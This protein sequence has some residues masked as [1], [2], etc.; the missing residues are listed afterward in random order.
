MFRAG[1]KPSSGALCSLLPAEAVFWNILLVLLWRDSIVSRTG[2]LHRQKALLND[3][4]VPL[5]LQHCLLLGQWEAI[6]YRE[7]LTPVFLESPALMLG[8]H[9]HQDP[10]QLTLLWPLLHHP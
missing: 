7:I 4:H 3:G 10:G 5:T 6:L 8:W 9:V 1:L 2:G